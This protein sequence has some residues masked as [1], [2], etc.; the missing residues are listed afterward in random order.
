MEFEYAN[1]D[2]LNENKKLTEM[3]EINK[4]TLN[5]KEKFNMEKLQYTDNADTRIVSVGENFN[6]ALDK[7]TGVSIC[8]GKDV[9]ETPDF[10]PLG[11]QEIN[12]VMDNFNY[13]DFIKHIN[14]LASIKIKKSET[15]FVSI[16]SEEE[17]N[18][19]LVCLSCFSVINL[20]FNDF[21]VLK[22][23]AVEPTE[24]FKSMI[25]AVDFIRSFGVSVMVQLNETTEVLTDD[26]LSAAKLL[27]GY[28]ILN[29]NNKESIKVFLGTKETAYLCLKVQ[30][31]KAN[32]NEIMDLFN[33][34]IA[35]QIQIKV[36]F[37]NTDIS[38]EDFV[39]F[40]DLIIARNLENVRFATCSLPILSKD[41]ANLKIMPMDCDATRFS[42]YV[43]N[44]K[45]Y[46]CEYNNTELADLNDCKS[47]SDYWYNT[48]IENFRNKIVEDNFC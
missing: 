42:I 45:L 37:I 8:W 21:N 17:L 34:Q 30:I 39:K 41:K 33:S 43:K 6:F 28:L 35:T 23:A 29:S 26:V 7:Q 44:G 5:S 1:L 46:P 31:N 19:N 3:A 32:Y 25:K 9:N 27:S 14:L 4:T 36:S 13:S 22:N 15:E 11:T 16:L 38:E 40:E 48:N 2:I 18:N 47:I 12:Y 20:I 10:D 24:E